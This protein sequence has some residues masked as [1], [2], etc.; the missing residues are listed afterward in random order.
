VQREL[1]AREP[2][3]VP[4]PIAREFFAVELTALS[5]LV[6]VHKAVGPVRDIRTRLA[7]GRPLSICIGSRERREVAGV[8]WRSSGCLCVFE[9]TTS[10]SG[11][12]RWP[13]VWCRRHR[14][15]EGGADLTRA[16][17]RALARALHDR[18]YV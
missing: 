17:S 2:G 9:D 14:K 1:R 18:G 11:S 3:P 8:L 5:A 4:Q 10:R 15:R 13:A 12:R 6:V 7:D 16:Q